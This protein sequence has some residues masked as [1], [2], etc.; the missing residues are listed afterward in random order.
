MKRIPWQRILARSRGALR[1]IVAWML[2]ICVPMLALLGESARG[3]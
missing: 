2:C 3:A 1:L